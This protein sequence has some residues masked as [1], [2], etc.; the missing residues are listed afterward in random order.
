[1]QLTVEPCVSKPDVLGAKRDRSVTGEETPFPVV[2]LAA[3]SPG[4][5]P[6]NGCI[7]TVCPLTHSRQV[8]EHCLLCRLCGCDVRN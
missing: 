3:E 2:G 5:A 1:M 8:E 7:Q 4:L 6:I